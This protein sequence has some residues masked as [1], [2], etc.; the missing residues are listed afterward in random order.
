MKQKPASHMRVSSKVQLNELLVSLFDRYQDSFDKHQWPWEPQRWYELVYCLFSAV[1]GRFGPETR[2]ASAVRVLMELGLLEIPV[3]AKAEET[4]RLHL[5]IVLE[6]IGF[7]KEQASQLVRALGDLAKCLDETYQGKVQL[8]LRT[9]GMELVNKVLQVLLLEDSLGK[10]NASLVVLHWLQNVLDLPV[11]VPS[12][13]LQTLLAET[14]A[15]VEEVLKTVDERNIN[16]ALLD[17]I[18]NRWVGTYPP[19]RRS[20]EQ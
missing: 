14:G 13:G 1:E 5:S 17:E 18:L 20:G 8:L 9:F 15:E 11:L 6:R 7:S 10:Q 3:L 4:T 2:S 19:Q 16:I 12:P